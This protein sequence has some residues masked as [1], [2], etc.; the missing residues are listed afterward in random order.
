MLNVYLPIEF[1]AKYYGTLP[2]KIQMPAGA[3][4]L[5]DKRDLLYNL[6]LGLLALP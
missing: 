2:L 3:F 6:K 4:E 5:H 1:R